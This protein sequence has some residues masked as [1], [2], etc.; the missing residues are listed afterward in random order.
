MKLRYYF[1]LGSRLIGLYCLVLA[2]LYFLPVIPSFFV[3][4]ARSGEEADYYRI[5]HVFLVLTPVLLTIVGLYL[6]RGGA[7]IH[8]VAF[9]ENDTASSVSRM[10]DLFTLGIKLYGVFLAAASIPHLLKLL[11]NYIVV[12]NSPYD[13]AGT[14]ADLVGGIETDFVPYLVSMLL[15]LYF[16]VWG[17]TITRLAFWKRREE[18]SEE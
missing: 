13:F 5:I 18:D 16:V 1:I 4:S 6:I 10:E 2:L 12:A 14:V 8:G 3:T 17:E 7:F 9:P 11:A 15:G